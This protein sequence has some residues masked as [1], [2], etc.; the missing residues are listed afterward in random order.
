M[1]QKVVHGYKGFEY[2]MT[3]RSFRYEPGRVYEM[4]GR[5]WPC[6]RG[7]HF[8]RKMADVFDY[9]GM[10]GCRYAEV[11][12]LGRVIDDGRKSVTDKLRVVR[13][14][15]WA[16]IL[17]IMYAQGGL[18]LKD[19]PFPVDEIVKAR[20]AGTLGDMLP[21]GTEFPVTFTNGEKNILVVCRDRDHT[22]LVT[23][24]LMAEPFVMD[25]DWS[26]EG[27]WADC[28]MRMHVYH[29]HTMLPEDIRKVIIPIYIQQTAPVEF[30]KC[31]NWAFLLSAV[32]V[33]GEE[34]C[35]PEVDYEDS[36]IDI[37]QKP[38]NRMKR[39]LGASG[40]SWWWL[41]S[42]HDNNFYARVCADGST[43]VC[44]A[45]NEGGV[46]VGFCIEERR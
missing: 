25:D 41:R 43:D 40:A 30:F 7:F 37:F 26:Y 24:Y 23:K 5:I 34:A 11:E 28:R 45:G 8:C 4:D 3:C 46:T 14:L 31:N 17:E 12:A 16:E 1:T 44:F 13:E 10:E 33:F 9:Y 39:R 6:E 38:V 32:N 35:C 20:E 29:I 36:Q 18:K 2:N 15:T 19:T 22:Y 21:S 42:A 27:S